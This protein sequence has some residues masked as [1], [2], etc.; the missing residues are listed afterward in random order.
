[1]EKRDCR[2]YKITTFWKEGIDED[3]IFWNYV[4]GLEMDIETA[5]QL[6]QYR[7]EYT[8]GKSV[9]TVI[10]GTNIKSTTKEARDYMN[11][12]EGG[13]KGVLG[14]AFLSNSVVANLLINLY[15]KVN[16]PTVPARFFTNKV[17]AISWLKKVKTEKEPLAVTL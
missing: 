14:G 8:K 10:D 11:S 12:A 1:M 4:P 3:I 9:Y 16:H 2:E 5:K 13:L 7:L 17:E 15:L 6:V